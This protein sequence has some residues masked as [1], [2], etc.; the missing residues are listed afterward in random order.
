MEAEEKEQRAA[1][2]S[3]NVVHTLPRSM[4]S[5]PQFLAGPLERVDLSAA[6]T[7]VLVITA[8]AE[9]AIGLAE[10]VLKMTGPGGVE[11][12]PITSARRSSRL[13]ATRPI[14]AAAGSPRALR[15]LI[16][17]SHLKLESVK[18]VVLAWAEEIL[19]GADQ[20]VE[21][22]EAVMSELPKDAAR[23]VVTSRAGT[24]VNEFAERYLR[25]AQRSEPDATEE[26]EPVSLRYITVSSGSR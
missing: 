9:T 17:S 23:I 6:A 2:R 5:V 13:F 14:H 18:T 26:L 22:L 1:G 16:Q 10:S 8:D 7:Q 4:A 15:E 3:L 11:L 19:T 24:R 20:D 25:R 12:L 21:A